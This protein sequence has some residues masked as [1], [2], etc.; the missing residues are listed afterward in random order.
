[1]NHWSDRDSSPQAF[2]FVFLSLSLPLCLP[3]LSLSPSP[4]VTSLPVPL[5]YFVWHTDVSHIPSF[6]SFL[7][8]RPWIHS[9]IVLSSLSIN[10]K[11][12]K[13]IPGYINYISTAQKEHEQVRVET[14]DR[15]R[16]RGRQRKTEEGEGMTRFQIL[17]YLIPTLLSDCEFWQTYS[18]FFYTFISVW[19]SRNLPS[20]RTFI[21]PRFLSLML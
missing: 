16:E 9:W 3:L 19:F 17:I 1:M 14:E 12:E 6:S 18:C 4:L 11:K 13:Y 10:E 15:G 5:L 2:R 21:F 8:F 20:S 7:C